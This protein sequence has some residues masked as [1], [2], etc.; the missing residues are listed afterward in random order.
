MRRST[1]RSRRPPNASRL[2]PHDPGFLVLASASP[3]RAEILAALG[4]PFQIDPANV[5]EEIRPG[6]SAEQAASRLAAEKA[7]EVAR[8]RPDAWV[9]AADTLVVLDSDSP[10]DPIHNSQFRIHNSTPWILGKPQSDTESAEILRRLSGRRHRVVT[11]VRLRRA[12]DPGW[13]IVDASS[14]KIALLSEEEIGWYVATGEPRDKAGA[15]AVQGLGARFIEAVEGSYT[16]VMGLPARA[17]YR[18]LTDAG[19]PTLALLA[20][21]SS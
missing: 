10:G 1:K 8:R 2:T 6:E 12:D 21:S 11:A 17:V 5:A 9:L 7:D 18:L 19:D 3:R 4:I 16:N 15:Y 20:L 13:E 14:V